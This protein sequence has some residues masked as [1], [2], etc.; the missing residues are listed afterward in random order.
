MTGIVIKQVA[1]Y[2]EDCIV[3][4]VSMVIQPG[5]PMTL[6][7]ETGSGK[8]LFAQAIMGAL[9]EGLRATGTVEIDGQRY[10]LQT[11]LARLRA[12][13]GHRIASLPQ[14]PG[15]RSIQQCV[16]ALRSRKVTGTCG[17]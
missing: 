14:E 1:V 11:D 6:V 8:S 7:G 3:E 4:P 10:D 17:A 9:P 16:S 15:W 13:W 5:K 2:A 12:Q